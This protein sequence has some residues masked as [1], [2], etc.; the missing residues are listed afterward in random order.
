M[1]NLDLAKLIR[2]LP[3][4]VVHAV[5]FT[6]VDSMGVVPQTRGERVLELA[7]RFPEQGAELRALALRVGFDPQLKARRCLPRAS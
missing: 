2:A 6:L 7:E 1:Y 5:A 4:G 3:E